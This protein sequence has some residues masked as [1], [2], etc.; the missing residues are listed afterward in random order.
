MLNVSMKFFLWFFLITI[1]CCVPEPVGIDVPLSKS[2]RVR[3]C[4]IHPSIFQGHTALLKEIES[5]LEEAEQWHQKGYLYTGIALLKQHTGLPQEIQYRYPMQMARTYLGIAMM[6][7][8]AMEIEQCYDYLMKYR[9]FIRM[10]AIDKPLYMAYYYSLFSRYYNTRFLAEKGYSYSELALDIYRSGQHD[11]PLIPDHLFYINHLGSIRNVYGHQWISNYTD[12]IQRMVREQYAT[13]HGEKSLALVSS[14][15][16]RLDSLYNSANVFEEA[17][18]NKIALADEL[19]VEFQT[20]IDLLEQQIGKYNTHGARFE[21]LV[22]LSYFSTNR[23][24]EAV[25]HFEK[26]ATRLTADDVISNHTICNNTST[27]ISAYTLKSRALVQLYLQT[28]EVSYLLENEKNLAFLEDVWQLYIQNRIKKVTDFKKVGYINNPYVEIVTNYILLYHHTQNPIYRKYIFE[29]QDLEKHYS[30]QY[31]I[32]QKQNYPGIAHSEVDLVA[33]EQ[34]LDAINGNKGQP[35]IWESVL[36]K[37]KVTPPSINSIS[38]QE[39]QQKLPPNRALI[40]YFTS[41][42]ELWAYVITSH[43]DT[44]FPVLDDL[45]IKKHGFEA[46]IY[47]SSSEDDAR[48]FQENNHLFYN[49]FI[50]PIVQILGSEI[51]ELVI[52]KSSFFESLGINFATAITQV[53]PSASFKNLNYI[54]QQYA[55]SF[56]PSSAIYFNAKLNPSPSPSP[57][58]LTV[59]VSENPSLPPLLYDSVFLRNIASQYEVKIVKGKDCNKQQFIQ[60]LQKERAILVISHGKGAYSDEIEENGLFLSDSFFSIK[61]MENLSSKCE[62]LILAG[63]S[64]GVGFKSDEGIID[65]AR[66]FTNAGVKSMILTSEDVD[67]ASTLKVL[68]KWFLYLSKGYSKSKALQLAQQDYLNNTTSRKSNPSYWASLTLIDHSEPVRIKTKKQQHYYIAC[69][70][71]VILGVFALFAFKKLRI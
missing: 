6:Y 11:K 66:G 9:H 54:G 70:M 46:L 36:H 22:G 2:T 57:K 30:L 53:V 64:T 16:W 68:E 38:A 28:H 23:F 26:A 10:T 55:I 65:M 58:I 24:K 1:V 51:D 31:L 71:L 69:L 32:Q 42:N 4:S 39:V 17:G 61:D 25:W 8:R 43:I 47:K 60:Y 21:N 59:F 12:T 52:I 33:F 20:Q 37:I 40:S 27:L 19:I 5:R 3:S 48:K 7:D 35:Q 13:Y 62:L 50:K 67:E 41:Q 63:C 15:L 18:P 45:L 44:F 14:V 34:L 56:S 49:S 29:S